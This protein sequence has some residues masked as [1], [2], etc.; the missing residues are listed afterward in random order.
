MKVMLYL[1]GEHPTLPSSE[2]I[3]VLK[4]E[5]IN[6]E[7]LRENKLMILDIDTE[8]PDF[9]SRLALTRYASEF[10]D[11]GDD[12]S[13]L[14]LPTYNKISMHETFAVRCI[15]KK[16]I[17]KKRIEE[18]LGGKIK[19][20]GMKVNLDNPD[21]EVL[22]FI[23]RDFFIGIK[24]S[25]L[26]L[27]RDFNVRKPQY[28]PY[29]HPTGM[30]PKIARVL[31][32]LARVKPSDTILDP[33][34][35]TGGILIEAGLM[36]MKIFGTDIDEEKVRG[37]RKNLK[38]YGLSGEIETANALK[39][40]KTKVDAVVTDPPYGR[41]SFVSEKNLK[42]FYNKFLKVAVSVLK[43]NGHVVLVLPK[44]YTLESARVLETHDVRVHRSLV[45]RI[46]VLG[47]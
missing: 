1:S 16:G 5:G 18:E 46:W 2:V 31:V 45:R 44:S 9:L 13:K 26:T 34:C 32:N 19:K 35:G 10:V 47:K 24:Y 11:K 36:E 25:F 15:G 12:L 8:N 42:E 40:K 28:R 41:S 6:Y 20:L 27:T 29:F 21:V 30:H 14:A 3:S 23:D 39:I 22:C 37:C 7:L 43:K 4:G 33:F 38:Y 17:G